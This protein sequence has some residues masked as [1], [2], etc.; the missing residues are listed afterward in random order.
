MNLS[1]NLFAKRTTVALI[2]KNPNK[3]PGPTFLGQRIWFSFFGFELTSTRSRRRVGF[4]TSTYSFRNQLQV[5][6]TRLELAELFVFL[7]V[8]T[9][10]DKIEGS[11][12]AASVETAINEGNQVGAYVRTLVAFSL[13]LEGD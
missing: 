5:T 4:E 10:H 9:F 11:R 1:K 6:S 8:F 12:L 2:K 13:R 3:I 7:D